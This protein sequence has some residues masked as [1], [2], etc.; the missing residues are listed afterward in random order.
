MV[1]GNDSGQND[2]HQDAVVAEAE[3]VVTIHDPPL[4]LDIPDQPI[5]SN[6][7]RFSPNNSR[8]PPNNSRSNS[9]NQRTI[10]NN[11]RTKQ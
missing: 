9:N 11:W 2:Q 6:N 7:T 4:L 3:L 10:P 8:Y 5:P 1:D